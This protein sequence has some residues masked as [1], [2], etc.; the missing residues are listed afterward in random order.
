[1]DKSAKPNKRGAVTIKEVARVAGKS[2]G[3]VSRVLN[4]HPD[5]TESSRTAVEAAIVRLGYEPN[6]VA[7][8]MRTRAKK[9]IGFMVNDI[10]NPLFATI[11]RHAEAVL[12]DNGYALVLAN[13]G[14]R[15]AAEVEL[16]QQFFRPRTD[17]AMLSL[18]DETNP[19]LLARLRDVELPLVL[20]DREPQGL[21]IDRVM[22]DHAE[23][24]RLATAYLMSLGH[25]RIALITADRRISPGR[26]RIDGFTAA[27]EAAGISVDPDLVR[28]RNLSASYAFQETFSL[29]SSPSPPTAIISGGNQILLGVMRAV[30]QLGVSVPGALS[31]ISCDSTDLAELGSPPITVIWRDLAQIGRAAADLLVQRLASEEEWRPRR[32][33]LPTELLV[34]DSCAPPPKK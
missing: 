12:H 7:Q 15:P 17:A 16:L 2:I 26:A 28:S 3:T 30:R 10:S 9:A 27:H 20:M 23:G 6:I 25:R 1:M 22:T 13:S 24:M 4:G 18:S 32:I 8:S 31:I 34:R 14:D 21:D 29:L 5:V 11:T 19:Q 33:M